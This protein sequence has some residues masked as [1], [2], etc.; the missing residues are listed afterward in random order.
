MNPEDAKA[1][2][3]KMLSD[4]DQ[5]KLYES[6][7]NSIHESGRVQKLTDQELADEAIVKVWGQLKLN[8]PEEAVVDELIRRFQKL[9]GIPE[10]EDVD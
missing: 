10:D 4:A 9:A 1:L 7:M 2:T 5:A 8:T 6:I 3:N